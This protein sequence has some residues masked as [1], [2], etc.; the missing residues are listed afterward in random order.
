MMN[1]ISRIFFTMKDFMD[2][3]YV[4]LKN[5]FIMTQSADLGLRVKDD[6]IRDFL[7][8]KVICGNRKFW[9]TFGTDYF[10]VRYRIV[11]TIWDY[12]G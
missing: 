2:F 7:A 8:M 11:Q 4:Y 10:I 6:T 1:T 5:V 12:L 3:A 9:F